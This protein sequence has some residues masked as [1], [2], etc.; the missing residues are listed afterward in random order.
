M[1]RKKNGEKN[2]MT[3]ADLEGVQ[4]VHS[5]P[6]LDQNY[7][8]FMGNFKRFFVKLGKRTPLSFF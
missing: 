7:F 2:E 8:I 1:K 6:P 3:V 4:W 5:N